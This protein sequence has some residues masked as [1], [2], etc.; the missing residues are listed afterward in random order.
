MQQRSAGI[1]GWA[2]AVL[3]LSFA[4]AQQDEAARAN[5]LYNAGKRP[6]ALPF[7]EDLVK[8]HPNAMI[9]LR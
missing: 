2:L 5:A 4:S 7:Y 8:A 1:C 6:D 3:A 9:R